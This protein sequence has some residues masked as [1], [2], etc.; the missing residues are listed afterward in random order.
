MDLIE[1]LEKRADAY[2]KMDE[3]KLL[4][5]YLLGSQNYGLE[6]EDSDID[7]ICIV[8]ND[9]I[10]FIKGRSGRKEYEYADGSKIK[11]LDLSDLYGSF[12]KGTLNMLDIILG[13]Y[14]IDMSMD[15]ELTKIIE[16]YRHNVPPIL[17]LNAAYGAF[18]SY[19]KKFDSAIEEVLK[20]KTAAHCLRLIF[21][22][23][24]LRFNMLYLAAPKEAQ[25]VRQGLLDIDQIRPEIENFEETFDKVELTKAFKNDIAK[26]LL[27]LMR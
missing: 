20:R 16:F 8:K 25:S 24:T 17:F 14:S 2:R 5:I 10:D 15:Y 3:R 6:T 9:P 23:K 4:G 26:R 27:K 13:D 21:L 18:L 7:V 22:M 1:E 11:V 19:R 12:V